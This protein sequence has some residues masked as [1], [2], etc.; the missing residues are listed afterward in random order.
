M[1]GQPLAGRSIV[2]TRPAG[3]ADSLC[4]ALRQ[5]LLGMLPDYLVPA[6]VMLLERL[7]LTANGKL[8]RK[9]LPLPELTSKTSGRVPEN[10]SEIAVAQG[11]FNFRFTRVQSRRLPRPR[12]RRTQQTRLF[13]VAIGQG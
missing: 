1:G 11:L 3:Q 2:V 8:D 12:L 6:Q 9:A 7:P 13:R 10:E 4:A 5:Q